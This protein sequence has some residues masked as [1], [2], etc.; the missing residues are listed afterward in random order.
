MLRKEIADEAGESL[1]NTVEL[2]QEELTDENM[3]ELNARVD[4]DKKDPASRAR[5]TCQRPA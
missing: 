1:T 2:I 5:S 3:Q 4:L